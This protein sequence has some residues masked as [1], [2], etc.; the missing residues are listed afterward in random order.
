MG[1]KC[2]TKTLEVLYMIR[3]KTRLS[4]GL[5]I[6]ARE[7]LA[8]PPTP[9]AIA[10]CAASWKR[11]SCSLEALPAGVVHLEPA[12]GRE[13]LCNQPISVENCFCERTLGMGLCRHFGALTMGLP[14]DAGAGY[15]N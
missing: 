13:P 14:C 6:Q 12:T 1:N 3:V 11:S 9:W 7:A 5:Y 10:G 8:A 4:Q 15:R 2:S